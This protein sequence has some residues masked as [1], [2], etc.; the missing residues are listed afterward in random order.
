MLP[1]GK[2]GSTEGNYM[3]EKVSE[4]LK[5]YG[6]LREKHNLDFI[7]VPQYIPTDHGTWELRIMPQVIPTD[8]SIP[9]PFVPES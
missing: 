1:T 3:E 8:Q 6:E 4:F 9:S 5:E 7:S 2:A